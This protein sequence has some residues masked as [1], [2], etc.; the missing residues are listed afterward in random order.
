M[1]SVGYA[2]EGLAYVARTQPNWRI[3][4][5]AGAAAV[6]AGLSFGLSLAELALVALTVGVVLAAELVNTAVEAAVDAM[7]RPPSAAAKHAK[8][9]AAG[10][11]LVAAMTSIVVAGLLFGP[12]ILMLVGR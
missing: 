3:E 2:I 1:R 6:A 7:D 8:D 4:I 5:A 12:K 9:A 10:A 11:V